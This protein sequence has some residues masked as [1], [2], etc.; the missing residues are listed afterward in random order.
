MKKRF[1]RC[2]LPECEEEWSVLRCSRCKMVHYCC[3]EHQALHWKREGK[4]GHRAECDAFV[5]AAL[6]S[7]SALERRD[8]L[9]A[10]KK[11]EKDLGS[12]A[13]VH[14][15]RGMRAALARQRNTVSELNARLLQIERT[16]AARVAP[17]DAGGGEDSRGPGTSAPEP[18]RERPAATEA[19]SEPYRRTNA[20]EN[21]LYPRHE[22]AAARG[23]LAAASAADLASMR[24]EVRRLRDLA[25]QSCKEM[26]ADLTSVGRWESYESGTETRD[27]LANGER[28]AHMELR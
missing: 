28:R 21:L 13:H 20:P 16:L 3:R 22:E 23:S 18:P 17:S 26:E 1:A 2:A 8:L 25:L 9:L 15:K 19:L 10:G 14:E 7:S 6:N 12:V 27:V 5:R 11:C 24:D 4:D